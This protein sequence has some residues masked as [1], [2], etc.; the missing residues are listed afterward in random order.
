[1]VLKKNVENMR[2]L[3]IRYDNG[4]KFASSETSL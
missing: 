3:E 4:K 2:N 1:M